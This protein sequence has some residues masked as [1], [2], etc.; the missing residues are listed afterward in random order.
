MVEYVLVLSIAIGVAL[1]IYSEFN[2]TVRNGY[3]V[4]NAEIERSLQTGGFAESSGWD[5]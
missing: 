2:R 4:L 5:Q 3:G 1:T